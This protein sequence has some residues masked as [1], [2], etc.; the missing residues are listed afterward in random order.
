MKVT[1]LIQI[2]DRNKK[3]IVYYEEVCEQEIFDRSN[4]L[5]INYFARYRTVDKVKYMP[6]IMKVLDENKGN[7]YVDSVIL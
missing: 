1:L 2:R 7:W 4:E 3:D 6:A 5:D